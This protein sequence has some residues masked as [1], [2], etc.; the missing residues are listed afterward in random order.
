MFGDCDSNPNLKSSF[1]AY[2]RADTNSSCDFN[3]APNSKSS[4]GP[5]E[6]HSELGVRLG[7]VH[8]RNSAKSPYRHKHVYGGLG[9]PNILPFFNQNMLL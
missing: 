5:N 7:F 1:Y 2:S 9:K 4:C 6:L 3:C 8:E